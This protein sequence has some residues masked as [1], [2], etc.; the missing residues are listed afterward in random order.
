VWIN[1][2][3][4]REKSLPHPGKKKSGLSDA[5]SNLPELLGLQVNQL[6]VLS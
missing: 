3:Q 6:L 2:R 4:R 5:V 1:I